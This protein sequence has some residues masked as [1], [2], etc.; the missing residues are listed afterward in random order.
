ME[1]I[2]IV[3]YNNT[4]NPQILCAISVGSIYSE[5]CLHRTSAS[6]SGIGAP[7]GKSWIRPEPI[8]ILISL[9]DPGG[10]AAGTPP[11]PTGSI[12][13]FSHMFSPKSVRIGGRRLPPNG[14][15]WIRHWICS[16]ALKTTFSITLVYVLYGTHNYV[17]CYIKKKYI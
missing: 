5:K 16:R 4:K 17:Y 3:R 10:G 8:H 9:A 12:S 15:S 1:I 2:N 7:N 13:F 14:K 6:P 11:P